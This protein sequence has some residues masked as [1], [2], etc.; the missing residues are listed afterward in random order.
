MWIL[1]GKMDTSYHALTTWTHTFMSPPTTH[2]IPVKE[3]KRNPTALHNT[4]FK[5]QKR[6]EML[7]DERPSECDYCW[8]V[9]DASDRFSDRV[10]KSGETWSLPHYDEIRNLDWRADYNPRYVEVAFSNACNFKCSYC[11]PAFLN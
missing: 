5:K 8:N 9:E 2:P 11:G 7:N 1:F 3:L 4:R 6:R 10:F